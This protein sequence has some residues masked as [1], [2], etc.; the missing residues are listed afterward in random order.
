MREA[1]HYVDRQS[2]PTMSTNYN[3][4]NPHWLCSVSTNQMKDTFFFVLLNFETK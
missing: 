4:S 3:V 2:Q 1:T